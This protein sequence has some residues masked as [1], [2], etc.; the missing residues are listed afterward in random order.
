MIVFLAYVLGMGLMMMAAASVA[1]DLSK[2]ALMRRFGASSKYAK[3]VS[4]VVPVVAGAYLIC[5]W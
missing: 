5:Y 3:R 2:G 1:V 4:G